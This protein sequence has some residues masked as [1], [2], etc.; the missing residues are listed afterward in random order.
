ML[1]QHAKTNTTH[2]NR[3]FTGSALLKMKVTEA[4]TTVYQQPRDECLCTA[5][6][7]LDVFELNAAKHK[8]PHSL[9]PLNEVFYRKNI[10]P[11]KNIFN[12]SYFGIKHKGNTLFSI[13]VNI[14]AR[15]ILTF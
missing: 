5:L 13:Q 6:F 8:T 10:Q 2:F 14:N 7:N 15:D 3:S 9:N 1:K 4:L 12:S 11:E